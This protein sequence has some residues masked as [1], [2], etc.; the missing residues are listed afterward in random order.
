MD[1]PTFW[2]ERKLWRRGFSHV[3]GVDEVGRGCFAGPVVAGAVVFP[4]FIKTRGAS[5]KVRG[6]RGKKGRRQ[7]PSQNRALAKKCDE[8]ASLGIDDSKKLR[9]RQREKLTSQIKN[10]A[11]AWDVTEIGVST[12]NRVG[13]GKATQKAMRKSVSDLEKQL[14]KKKANQSKNRSG[15]ID[16][17]LVDAFYV[18]YL[19]GLPVGRKLR[20]SDKRDGR[21][22]AIINGD[23]RSISIAAASILAKVHRDRLMHRLSKKYPQYGW[24]KNKGYGTRPHQKAIERCGL[25]RYHRRQFVK[26]WQEKREEDRRKPPLRK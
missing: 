11:L 19:K 16:Y 23:A 6:L 12:I 3:V 2:Q 22:K 13:I 9:P 24:G 21:Q 4:S 8:I 10:F 20:R 18:S 7:K 25:T 1:K 15:L 26:T 5:L 17:V 14:E